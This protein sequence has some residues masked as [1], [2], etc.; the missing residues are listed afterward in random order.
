MIRNHGLKKTTAAVRISLIASV[1]LLAAVC[2]YPKLLIKKVNEENRPLIESAKEKA[3][4]GD[5]ASARIDTERIVGNLKDRSDALM[6]FY[7]HAD[8]LELINKADTALDMTKTMDLGLLIA[9]LGDLENDLDGLT[10][11]N[12]VSLPNII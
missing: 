3:N 5:F 6:L 8:I 9:A 1:I 11:V 2:V 10:R 4:C 12:D 7:G